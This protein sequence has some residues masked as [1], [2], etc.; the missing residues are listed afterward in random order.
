MSSNHLTTP[1]AEING[2]KT[3][4]LFAS[5]PQE[6]AEIKNIAD[7]IDYPHLRKVTRYVHDSVPL[8]GYRKRVEIKQNQINRPVEAAGSS[9]Q[10]H[11]VWTSTEYEERLVKQLFLMEEFM[12]GEAA[13]P[14]KPIKPPC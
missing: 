2:L 10:E 3:D 8:T 5:V 4:P 6:R 14:C 12:L 7:H 9:R 13:K 1:P 11:G